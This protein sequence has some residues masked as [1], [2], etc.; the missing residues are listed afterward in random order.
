MNHE[1]RGSGHENAQIHALVRAQDQHVEHLRA[2]CDGAPAL[3]EIE[4]ICAMAT[5]A[6]TSDGS[7][8]PE[9]ISSSKLYVECSRILEKGVCAK[10]LDEGT[11]AIARAD[12]GQRLRMFCE[13]ERKPS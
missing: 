2:G 6:A 11:R 9:S 8:R 13:L 1:K 10:H 3:A 5:N 7:I 12:L 4:R